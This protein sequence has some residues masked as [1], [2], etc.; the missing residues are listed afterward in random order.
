MKSPFF[1]RNRQRYY[2]A[3]SIVLA[4]IIN[5]FPLQGFAAGTSNPPLANPKA[6]KRQQQET[7]QTK[8]EA[9]IQQEEP[10]LDEQSRGKRSP[11]AKAPVLGEFR[12]W[13]EQYS[14]AGS[15]SASEQ[16]G[17]ELARQRRAI[18]AKLVE[19]DP[20]S[21]IEQAVPAEMRRKLP[22][23]IQVDVEEQISSYGDY[24]VMVFDGVDPA[25][26]ELKHGRTERKVVIEGKI[27]QAS[28]YGHKLEMTTKMNIPLRGVKMD[29]VIALA[30]SPVRVLKVEEGD[31]PSAAPGIDAEVGGKIL[32]FEDQEQLNRF[33]EKLK[34]REMTI[35]PESIEASSTNIT[36]ATVADGET[37]AAEMAEA[38]GLV[39]ASPWTEGP[40]TVLVI[41]VDFSD[42]PGEPTDV[43]GTALTVANAQNLVN[44][45]CNNFYKNNSYNKT[46]FAATVTTVL[47]MPQPST[48]Y[49]T[50]NNPYQLMTDARAAAKTAGFDSANYNLE[51]LA[52]KNISGFWWAGLGYIGAKGSWLNGYFDLRVTVHELGHNYGLHHANFWQPTAGN[53]IGSGPSQEYGDPFDA[54]GFGDSTGFRHFNSWSKNVLNWLPSTDVQ[55]VEAS[56]THL[57]QAF[58]SISSTGKRALKIQRDA[59]TYYWVEFRQA[60]IGQMMN[61]DGAVIHWG[62]TG[63][64]QSNLLDMTPTS[65]NGPNDASLGIGQTF[66]DTING[67]KITTVSKSATVPAALSVS[68]TFTTNLNALALNPSPV[69]GGNT[70]TGTVTLNA[71]APTMG[72]TV[73]LSDNLAATTLP[74]TVVI[75]AGLTSKTFTITTTSVAAS[76]S[77]IVTASYRGVNKTAALTVQPIA[78]SSLTL[79]TSDIGGGGTVTGTVT[80]NGPAPAAGATI[81]LADN[82]AA[83]TTPASV[84]IPA[85]LKTKT[86]AITTVSVA[87]SQ[88]GIVTASYGGVLKSMPLIVGPIALSSIVV[89]PTSVAGG[90]NVTGTVTLNGPAPAAGVV[91]TLSDNLPATTVP[92]SVTIPAGSMSRTFTITTVIVAA[93]QS[94][95]VTAKQGLI[96]KLAALTV[97]PAMLTSVTLVP[98]SVAGGNNVTGTISLDGPAPAA[99]ALVTL[100]DNLTTATTPASALIAPGTTSKTFTI[101]TVVVTARFPGAVTASYG[102][103]TKTTPL[104]VRPV[105]VQSITVNPNPIIGSS[106]AVGTI[107]LERLSTTNTV[108]SLTDNLPATTIPVSVT[109]NAG[110]LSQTF[111]V[112]TT[113]AL[114]SQKGFLNA[115]ANG[116]VRSVA[117]SVVNTQSQLLANPGFELG[118]VAWTMST[119]T[120]TKII[121]NGNGGQSHT[122]VWSAWL[123]GYGAAVS[124]H[125]YQDVTIPANALSANL[126]FY[127]WLPTNETTMTLANDT[128][129]L[130]IQNTSGVV[131]ATPVIYSNLNKT[132][133]FERRTINLLPYKGQSIRVFFLG[134]ENASI[135]TWF[136]LDD[137][138]LDV[139]Q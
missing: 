47:R 123:G 124:E 34:K 78:L 69:V 30:E 15:I 73:A 116:E 46:S 2:V 111:P 20:A 110:T 27:Y 86:F 98:A 136:F 66:T 119:P 129:R 11:L 24:L 75:P 94:G 52:F 51:L 50:N 134:T 39:A 59:N 33:E 79:S 137:I 112:T 106:S 80:L 118:R 43:N 36:G 114:P 4:L 13:L 62:Y 96:T 102:G 55:T 122:G 58:D 44:T 132:I 121:Y 126:N 41:R 42:K 54:M 6:V 71:P 19:D 29:G 23:Q 93:S 97:R 107:V 133:G 25:S 125:I 85:G 45:L 1:P 9:A 56:G 35:G 115:S 105:S 7:S 53:P 109:V 88:S 117:L 127:L 92:L 91:V 128:L 139:V 120:S 90:V 3:R 101:T 8:R 89:S 57:I 18:M 16:R 26:G 82:I 22:A 68:V 130:Q 99:G 84:V 81:T 10:S 74:A 83:A 77:G 14:I 21:A 138:T 76:Q 135:V 60:L 67:I 100:A 5:L 37:A 31:T 61:P 63:V 49:G 95:T 65:G 48:W 87:I 108:V 12:D 40:K 70:I 32:H 104:T 28:V 113:L 72:A 103:V 131:L 38:S 64:T 17:Q